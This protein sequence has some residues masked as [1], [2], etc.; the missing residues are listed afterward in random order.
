MGFIPEC[1]NDGMR[2]TR[3]DCVCPKH[4]E[5]NILLL[6]AQDHIYESA[7]EN[8]NWPRSG[9]KIC[10]RKKIGPGPLSGLPNGS[11]PRAARLCKNVY[12]F[13]HIRLKI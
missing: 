10:A 9:P 4:Y 13:Y 1:R 6:Y 11:N 12:N 3:G 8:E 7:G 5:G 2:G